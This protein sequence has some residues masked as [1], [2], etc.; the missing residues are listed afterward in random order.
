MERDVHIALVY[1]DP[2]INSDVIAGFDGD[3]QAP[4]LKVLVESVPM[5]G[6][7][8]ALEWLMPTAIVAYIAKPYFTAFLTEMG[9]DHY[10]VTKKAFG[11][12][13]A[14]INER[15]GERLK[16]VASKGKLGSDA[17]KFSPV[18][19]IEAQSPCGY[20]LKLLV[21]TDMQ[22]ERFNLAI[23]AYFNLLAQIYGTEELTPHSKSLLSNKPACSVLL[24]CF[25]E[26]SRE[27]EHVNPMPENKRP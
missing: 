6:A 11:N 2:I 26:E 23:E 10:A 18:F 22:Q 17:H 13:R 14:R 21:Q 4:G 19:S 24:V 25:N 9:K 12:L 5:M 20:R 3:I 16:L 8:S 7:R 15:F 27:L 1:Q